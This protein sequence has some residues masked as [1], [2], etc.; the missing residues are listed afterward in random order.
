MTR[1]RVYANCCD[2]PE[3][4]LSRDLVRYRQYRAEV[5]VGPLAPALARCAT[6]GTPAT[7]ATITVRVRFAGQA[8]PRCGG[9]CLAGKRSCDCRCNG[10][11]HGAGVCR[12]A[13]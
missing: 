5:Q 9:A 3:V 2:R 4:D 1:V 8:A 12:C 13:A 11:C 10:R 7:F 6:C